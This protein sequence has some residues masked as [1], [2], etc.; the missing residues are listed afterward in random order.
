MGGEDQS[1]VLLE[2]MDLNNDGKVDYSEFLQAAI[3]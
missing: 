1:H 2:R 3:D